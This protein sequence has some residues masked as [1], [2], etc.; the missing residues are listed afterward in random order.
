MASEML[1]GWAG[2]LASYLGF[3]LLALSNERHWCD[4][5]STAEPMPGRWPLP[6]GAGLQ[7]LAL[8]FATSSQG[9]AF[10]S[11]LWMVMVSAAAVAVAFTLSWWPG[12]LKPLAR[13]MQRAAG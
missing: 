7:G 8:W 1:F 6:A 3:A 12:A 4:V 9:A 2:A 10:G 5:A 11:L 13:L